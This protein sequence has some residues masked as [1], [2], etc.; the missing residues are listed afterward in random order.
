L[1]K[2]LPFLKIRSAF[3]V[4]IDPDQQGHASSIQTLLQH[5]GFRMEAG[6]R[7]GPGFVLSA[8]RLEWKT[9]AKAA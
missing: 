2:L 8:R 5:A 6:S 4:W 3:A 9:A 1:F 7:C